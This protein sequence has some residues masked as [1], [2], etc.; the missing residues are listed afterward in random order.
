MA[1]YKDPNIPETPPLQPEAE[2]A[3]V[4]DVTHRVFFLPVFRNR[5]SA[6]WLFEKPEQLIQQARHVLSNKP[7]AV[8]RKIITVNLPL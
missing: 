6:E 1:T 7:F 3:Q 2:P 8:E 4:E 5:G